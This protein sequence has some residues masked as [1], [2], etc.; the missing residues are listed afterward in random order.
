MRIF[1]DA[2]GGD[3]APQAPVD[4]ALEALRL[5]PDLTIV[6]AGDLNV[7]EPLLKDC[8]ELRSRIEL[9]DAPEVITND[10]SPVM[11]VRQKKKSATVT[12]IIARDASVVTLPRRTKSNFGALKNCIMRKGFTDSGYSSRTFA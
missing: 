5:Y 11:G 3:N 6:L 8:G 12:T 7:V 9:V 2:M 1:L 10:E 4:G